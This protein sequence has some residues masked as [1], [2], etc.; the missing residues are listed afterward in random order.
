[1]KCNVLPLQP[2]V[3]RML[4]FVDSLDDVVTHKPVGRT[5]QEKAISVTAD[6]GGKVNTAMSQV[7]VFRCRCLKV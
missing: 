4:G 2:L 6:H 1:M 7:G 3:G 5:L